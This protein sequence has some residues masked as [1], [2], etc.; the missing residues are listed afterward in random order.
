MVVFTKFRKG[1]GVMA[2]MH[3]ASW[4][5]LFIG[6]AV[7]GIFY[8]ISLVTLF[9]GKMLFYC[10]CCYCCSHCFTA[11]VTILLYNCSLIVLFTTTVF[12]RDSN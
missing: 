7:N 11:A 4:S 2:K 12:Y 6:A 9:I 3:G 8:L 5:I 10:G 1:A